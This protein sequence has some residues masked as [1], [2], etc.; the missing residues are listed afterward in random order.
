M[1]IYLYIY[2]Y[3]VNGKYNRI[4]K[5]FLDLGFLSS[6]IRIFEEEKSDD[7]NIIVC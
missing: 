4:D 2:L 7:E 1:F 5:L 3:L 6:L